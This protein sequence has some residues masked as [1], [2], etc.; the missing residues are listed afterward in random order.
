MSVTSA[1]GRVLKGVVVSSKNHKTITV[2]V[3]RRVQHPL[4]GKFIS[5]SK[6]YAVHDENNV[7]KVG[8]IVNFRECPPRS[9]TKTWEVLV[10]ENVK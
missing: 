9:K 7:Y 5:R 3:Q 4:F 2:L 10:S 1:K 6:K 8:D